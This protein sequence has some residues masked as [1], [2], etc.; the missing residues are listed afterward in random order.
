MTKT[1]FMQKLGI[2]LPIDWFDGFGIHELDKD[3]RV[4]IKL[5]N[6]D[7]GNARWNGLDLSLLSKTKGEITRATLRFDAYLTERKDNRPDWTG[8]G[9]GWL[10]YAWADTAR[11]RLDAI[12][13]YI[14]V[15]RTTKPLAEA[16]K[17]YVAAWR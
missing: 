17:R 13:W 7:D 9:T 1:E 10:F 5:S 3:R 14:A 12:D 15:P 16:V 11:R 6:K 8:H 2:D 4:I